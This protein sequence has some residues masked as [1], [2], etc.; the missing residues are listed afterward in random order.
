MESCPFTSLWCYMASKFKTMEKPAF[1]S[2][3][4]P[5]HDNEAVVIQDSFMPK[6]AT[7]FYQITN[8]FNSRKFQPKNCLLPPFPQDSYKIIHDLCMQFNLSSSKHRY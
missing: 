6:L 2:D 1:L 7:N 3:M 8:F 4:S 5:E